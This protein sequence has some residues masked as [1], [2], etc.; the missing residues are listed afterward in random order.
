MPEVDILLIGGGVASATTAV[1]LRKQGIPGSVTLVTRELEPPY[2]RPPVSKQ[3]L[4]PGAVDYDAAVLPANWWAE[5][6]VTLRTRTSVVSLDP[7]A[8]SATLADGSELHYHSGLLATGANVRRLPLPGS[9][10]RGV[11]Y[12]RAPGNAEKL[13]TEAEQA[14]RAV[15]V[16]GSFVATEVAA[17]LTN[18]GV[19]CTMVMP[20]GAP[21]QSA[22]GAAA[23]R[24]VARLLT[25]HG[26]RLVCGEQ[27][28]E[29][30][31]TERADGV[32]TSTGRYLPADLVVVGVGAIPETRLAARAGVALGSTG[33]I[34]CDA[35]L[36]TSVAGL[37][38]AG[39]VCEYDSVVH[40]RRLRVEHEEH[41]AA[42]GVTAAH[43]LLA[44]QPHTSRSPTSGPT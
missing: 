25:E 16:G 30:T 10:L 1:E 6:E 32:R 4:G 14:Q 42:Q 31:G 33:G 7:V 34:A 37:Y 21:L 29:F 5:H 36:R 9:A 24:Y 17:S 27:A 13:R 39:D 18:L 23:A 2:H 15:L 19:S 40:Q 35:T 26:V 12:L 41:A 8:R 43:G 38:A 3:L 44:N 11:H 28:S 22:L 20:E